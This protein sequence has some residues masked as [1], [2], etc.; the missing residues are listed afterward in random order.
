MS[1]MNIAAL[2]LGL[3]AGHYI[4]LACNRYQANK[5]READKYLTWTQVDRDGVRSEHSILREPK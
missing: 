2:V 5:K 4:K 1:N 3:I